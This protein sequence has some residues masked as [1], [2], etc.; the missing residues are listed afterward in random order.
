MLL[1]TKDHTINIHK[2]PLFFLALNFTLP[3]IAIKTGFNRSF[4]KGKGIRKF[5]SKLLEYIKRLD[6]LTV[7]VLNGFHCIDVIL[8]LF[9]MSRQCS[10]VIVHAFY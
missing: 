9:L 5:R 3:T 10:F 2:Q 1:Q 4:L 6:L 7:D 8:S